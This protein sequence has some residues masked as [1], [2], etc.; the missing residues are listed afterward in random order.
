[1]VQ[2]SVRVAISS[3]FLDAFA[4]IPKDQQSK[5]RRFIEQFKANPASG[6]I[7]YEKI[8]TFKD[9]KLRSV[10]IDQ[11][12][13]GI[14]M[15]PESGDIYTL[16]WVAHH[17]DAYQWAQ[18]K[19]CN[20]H[21]DTG[22]LQVYETQEIEPPTDG[23]PTPGDGEEFDGTDGR[24]DLFAQHRDREL[25]RLGVPLELMPLVRSI[26][27]EEEL[28]RVQP[29]LPQEAYEVLFLL[30][31]GYTLLE[32][33]REMARH[34][35]PPSQE[36]DTE[37]FDAA[38]EHP[39]SQRRFQVVDDDLELLEILSAPLEKWRVFLHPSQRRT[40]R[41]EA[42][43]PVRVLGGAGTGKTVVA[44]H[45][46]K[47]LVERV[48]E[49]ADE[50][51]LFTT[52]TRN[53]AADIEE[54]LRKICS[55]EVMSRIQVVNLDRWVNEF[56]QRQ[57]YEYQVDFGERTRDLWDDAMLLIP[58]ELD[59]PR[60]FYRE[61]WEQVIQPHEVTSLPEYMRVARVGRGTRISRAQRKLIWPIFQEYQA[62]LNEKQLRE[63]D[64]AMR[65]AR[66]IL[67]D[68]GA[69]LPY[70]SIV[71]DEAQDLGRQAFKLIRAMV[72]EKP[73]D[74]FIVGD[75]HQ[76]I[77]RHPIVLGQCGIDIVGRGRRLRINY[78]TT[79]ETRR[80]AVALLEGI[81]FDDLDGGAETQADHTSLLRG[82]DP[83]VRHFDSFAEEV[84]YLCSYLESL[85]EEDRSRTCLVARTKKWVERYQG[86]LEARGIE[87]Y[88]VRRS[89]AE[90]RSAV[91][92]RLATMHR[93][94]GLEFD[95]VLVVAVNHDVLPL[96]RALEGA[97]GEAE[98]E[99]LETRE[100]SLLYVAATRARREVKVTSHGQPSRLLGG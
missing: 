33:D 58:P 6:G 3:D 50:R 13:R 45:R 1:M 49:G 25:A 89:Q 4:Q 12:Y 90:D 96:P 99:A 67:E 76:R 14:V 55:E 73:N 29:Y 92:L 21:P 35:P 9:Q 53:L 78:R 41:M 61:E 71:V 19:V 17:D 86:A 93:V 36:V 48:L 100:R 88:P 2:P 27:T 28:D 85:E 18:N 74:I 97:A 57:G 81:P 42:N 72:P 66:L 8:S 54:N 79:E 80:W 34:R 7:N 39:D 26:E 60:A 47:Y 94:K 40:V 87:T 24:T 52:F 68:R 98:R 91:G 46:A 38:L 20:I 62:L 70:R 5:V 82:L 56:L 15:K 64:G 37:D 30:A 69:I 16:L 32:V 59:F 10:R 31:A 11:S 95:R 63:P 77:Y 51:L 75:A 22:A 43:G 84:D 44:M 65:D 83:E 23:G